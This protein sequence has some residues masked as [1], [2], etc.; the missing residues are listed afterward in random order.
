MCGDTSHTSKE[1]SQMVWGLPPVAGHIVPLSLLY[2]NTIV[3]TGIRE[4]L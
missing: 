3:L 1:G 2:V 4:D